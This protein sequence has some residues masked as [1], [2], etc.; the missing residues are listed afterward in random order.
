[1]QAPWWRSKTETC[2][3]PF[4]VYF[5]VNFNV[6]FKLIKVH[7][8]VSELYIYQ[9][10][11]C[12]DKNWNA[13]LTINCVYNCISM[14]RFFLALC[15]SRHGSGFIYRMNRWSKSMSSRMHCCEKRTRVWLF[16]LPELAISF[17][18]DLTWRLGSVT[19]EQKQMYAND[20]AA[21][22]W[23]AFHLI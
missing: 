12:N 19:A 11:R 23:C 10:A 6:F 8:L 22:L 17:P 18:D 9:N 7:L 2:T 1:M 4:Y 15:G 5:N 13:L 3:S 14:P 16:S 20:M 21:V